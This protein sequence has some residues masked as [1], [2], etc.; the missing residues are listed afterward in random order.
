M[1]KRA[2]FDKDWVDAYFE[3][4]VD[5]AN[6]RVFI[7]DIDEVSVDFAIKGLYLMETKSTNE[8]C[9]MFISSY[10]GTIYDALALYDIMNTLRC[11]IHTFAYGKCMSAAPLLLAAGV[12]G[13][14]WVAPHVAFM[15][16]DW[17]DDVEGTGSQLEATIKH[18][19]HVGNIW[20]RLLAKHSN[21][22][23]KW[24]Q[25][26]AKKPADFFFSADDAIEWGIADMMWIEKDNG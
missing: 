11:P 24:W 25:A 4:G 9:E 1:S 15:H 23:F 10:G 19:E 5:V 20:T 21:K 26:R 8:P 3:N 7:G 2:F 14:R 18:L 12:P 13:Q 22:D 6:R 16:H 17:S